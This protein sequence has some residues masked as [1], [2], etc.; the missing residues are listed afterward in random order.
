YTSLHLK[1][2]RTAAQYSA[3][4]CDK[5]KRGPIRDG[6]RCPL[7]PHPTR[8]LPFVQTLVDALSCGS[9]DVA[10]FT[11]GHLNPIRGT[12]ER[13]HIA[14]TE[15]SFGKSYRQLLHGDFSHLPVGRA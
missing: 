4:V 1:P 14:H 11:L 10:Q 2:V 5:L 6:D 15:Q 3:S 7:D 13:F 9:D 12:A 8:P